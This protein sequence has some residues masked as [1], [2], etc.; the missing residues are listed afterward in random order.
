MGGFGLLG[1]LENA[2]AFLGGSRDR[3]HPAMCGQSCST[4]NH[5]VS[6]TILKCFAGN[7]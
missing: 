5:I 2:M 6:Y 1:C 4:K 3:Q 7:L